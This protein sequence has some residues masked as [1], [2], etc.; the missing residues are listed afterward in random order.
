MMVNGV[1]KLTCE[2]LLSEFAPGPVRVA[3]LDHFPV[4]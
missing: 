3:P 2:T 1:P 4:D